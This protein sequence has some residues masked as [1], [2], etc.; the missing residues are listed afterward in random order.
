MGKQRAYGA[1]ATLKAVRETQYG[2]ATTGAVRSLDFKT[3]DLSS[4]IPLGDDP[5]LGRGRNA[6]DPYRGLVTDEGQIEIPFDLQGTGWWMTALFGDPV[7]TPQ[8]ATGRITF[9]DN[10]SPGA[11]ITLNGVTWSFVSGTAAGNETEIGATLAD[12]LAALVSEL[13]ASSAPEIRDALAASGEAA[14]GTAAAVGGISEAFD[15]IGGTGDAAAA[16]GGGG[17]SAG[18][19][20]EAATAAG[21]AIAEAGEVASTA[22]QQVG[23]SLRDYADRAMGTGSQVSD[24]LVSAFRGA[25]DALTKMVT[26]GKISFSDLANSILTD[27]T[28]I[29]LRSAVLGPLANLLGGAFGGGGAP[30]FSAFSIGGLSVPAP[31][32]HTGGVIGDSKLPQRM[33][34]AAAF[35]GAERFHGGGMVGLRTGPSVAG[36]RPDEVPAILQRGERVLSRREVAEERRGG[37][38]T[39]N[40]T[41]TTPDA[42][43]FRRSEGQIV[44]D[45]SRAVERARRNR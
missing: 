28:R 17:S 7:T 2:G 34:P 44:A 20:A 5:L 38:V 37:G 40:M 16:G 15:A 10:P 21:A 25:E 26:T 35:A 41:I 31:V 32:A 29:A 4:R 3:T 30:G 11:T 27:I 24:A 39:V 12:T 8:A 6:Q 19:A 18:R 23:D 43:S 45:L 33:V 9:A 36:L 22:W 1:D 13:N 14:D 42:Q